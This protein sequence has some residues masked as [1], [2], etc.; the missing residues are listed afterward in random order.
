MRALLG[1][2]L[3]GRALSRE[4]WPG[5][6]ALSEEREAE[7][8]TKSFPEGYTHSGEEGPSNKAEY[9]HG[10]RSSDD[11][12]YA[13]VSLVVEHRG[14][15][16]DA[17]S[18]KHNCIPRPSKHKANTMRRSPKRWITSGKKSRPRQAPPLIPAG[19]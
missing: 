9:C 18:Q 17:Y 10:N 19:T 11:T 8:G 7:R 3:E 2:I 12:G 15:T 13:V 6:L 4:T 1:E 5:K 14:S 16:M